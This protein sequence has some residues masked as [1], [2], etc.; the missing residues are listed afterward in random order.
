MQAVDIGRLD[1]PCRLMATV[2]TKVSKHQFYYHLPKTCHRT[3]MLN[4]RI[5]DT[6]DVF[7][8][9]RSSKETCSG[10]I[11]SFRE[12]YNRV[13][14]L[15]LVFTLRCPIGRSGTLTTVTWRRRFD[16]NLQRL[17]GDGGGFHGLPWRSKISHL[18]VGVY[19]PIMRNFL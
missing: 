2:Y 1:F 13:S 11:F 6:V 17:K 19:M 7:P 5:D 4:P 8:L 18:W 14:T 3:I 9:A 12:C 15:R 10:A 16:P